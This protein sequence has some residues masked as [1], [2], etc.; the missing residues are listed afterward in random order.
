MHGPA[1]KR[2][3]EWL[4]VLGY[5]LGGFEADGWYGNDTFEAVRA[6]QRDHGLQDD[7]V[8]GDITL[9]TI[10]GA[11]EGL[12]YSG[13]VKTEIV[14]PLS[15]EKFV[16]HDFRGLDHPKN[17]RPGRSPMSIDGFTLHQTGCL[18]KSGYRRW[19]TVNAH[20]GVTREGEIYLLNDFFDFIWHAQGLSHHTVGIEVSGNMCGIEGDLR[21]HW[22][23]GGGPHVASS[24]Q[25]KAL[26]Q[27]L[28]WACDKIK[29][30]QKA[31]VHSIF[32]HRQSSKNRVAD[33]GSRL[34]QD[35]GLW[36]VKHL[37]LRDGEKGTQ[38]W[39]TGNPL[40]S[41]WNGGRYIVDYFDY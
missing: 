30:T 34:W 37:G 28:P 20:V 27:F 41:Q 33:P 40:P 18:I 26:R 13:N 3:Q 11:I 15:A 31:P 38:T 8:V 24:A 6:F 10:E 36:A 39:G 35:V 1:V 21:T 14:E 5:S 7:G 22:S 32:A 4:L 19:R 9:Q 12:E 29:E 2:I 23:S 16:I 25:I 17:Y